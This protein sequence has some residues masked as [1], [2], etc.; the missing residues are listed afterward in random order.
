MKNKI[1]ILGIVSILIIA[2]T[3]IYAFKS[4]SKNL[5]NGI[6]TS[7]GICPICDGTGKCKTCKG[8]GNCWNCNRIGKVKC[9]SCSGKGKT[10]GG[11]DPVTYHSLPD[12]TCRECNGKGTLICNICMGSGKCQAGCTR[13]TCNNCNGT[14]KYPNN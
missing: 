10:S 12:I 2:S 6:V 1:K 3:A 8:S 4:N 11:Y 5:N 9:S 7:S 14:G 13:G